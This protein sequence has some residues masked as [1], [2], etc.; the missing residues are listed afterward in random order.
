MTFNFA[1]LTRK[2]QYP[3]LLASGSLPFVLMIF[4]YTAQQAMYIAW[5][6]PVLYLLLS[7]AA[8]VIAGK[9]RLWFGIG[10]LCVTLLHGILAAVLTGAPTVIAAS[11]VYGAF[12]TAGLRFAAWSWQDELPRL[13]YWLGTALHIAAQILVIVSRHDKLTILDAAAPWFTISFLV[14]ILLTMLAINRSAQAHAAMQRQKPSVTVQKRNTVFVLVFFLIVV[15]IAAVPAVTDALA[16]AWNWLVDLLSSIRLPLADTT[17]TEPTTEATTVS[18]LEDEG[19]TPEPPNSFGLFLQN[20]LMS[21]SRYL[22]VALR[23]MAVLAL[24]V[25]AVFA[26]WMLVRFTVR[27]FKSAAK[28]AVEVTEDYVD[29]ITDTRD[30]TEKTK[31]PSSGRQLFFD[32]RK[33]PPAERIR[34]RYRRLMKKH[35]NWGKSSTAR[36]NLP[37]SLAPYYELARYSGKEVTEEQAQTFA[38]GTKQIK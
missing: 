38:D 7:F 6:F 8:L 29:E 27:L 3:L 18:G 2:M 1:G 22:F 34:Y 24:L 25:G 21:L 35:P 15:L 20:L 26:I 31:R 37:D 23:Y 13:C 5:S 33:L 36:D 10:A 30:D 4:S 32:D 9:R 16:A 12:F 11:V 14:F 28:Y 19:I 17:D